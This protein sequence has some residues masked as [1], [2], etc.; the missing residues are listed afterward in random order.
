MSITMLRT[1]TDLDEA[2]K[3]EPA[4]N[5]VRLSN[6]AT[7]RKHFPVRPYYSYHAGE[8]IAWGLTP[9]DAFMQYCSH[10]RLVSRWKKI[11]GLP[12]GTTIEVW[13]TPIHQGGKEL[14][15]TITGDKKYSLKN[16]KGAIR[17]YDFNDALYQVIRK[18]PGRNLKIC[19]S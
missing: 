10:I 12:V 5:E 6:G 3:Y 15:I 8:T 14:T 19:L 9:I 18:T 1:E 16:H 7:L 17:E 2:F 11:L 4:I 13:D